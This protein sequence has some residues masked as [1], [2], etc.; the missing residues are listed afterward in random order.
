VFAFFAIS[1]AL[2]SLFRK[3]ERPLKIPIRML[4]KDRSLQVC[5]C[6]M[7]GYLRMFAVD[8]P[9]RSAEKERVKCVSET[10]A[11]AWRVNCSLLSCP[12]T[13]D[14]AFSGK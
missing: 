7:N 11:S 12:Q 2:V 5:S 6:E 14:V 4:E 1:N 13:L 10:L 3:S 8:L 9:G